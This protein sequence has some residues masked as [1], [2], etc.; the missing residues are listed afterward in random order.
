MTYGFYETP[1]T[2]R[3]TQ[4]HDAIVGM[5]AM[6]A[7]DLANNSLAA[8]LRDARFAGSSG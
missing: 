3:A 2:C 8:I 1:L 5:L 7:Q 6:A 4:A